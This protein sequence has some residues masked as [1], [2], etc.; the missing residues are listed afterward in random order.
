MKTTAMR[1]GLF[2]FRSYTLGVGLEA[3][4]NPDFWIKGRLISMA[5]AT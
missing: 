4:K 1:A 5:T 3:V 2:K